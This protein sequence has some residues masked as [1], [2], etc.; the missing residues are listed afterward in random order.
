MKWLPLV[1]AE[2]AAGAILAPGLKVRF[3][4]GVNMPSYITFRISGVYLFG[5]R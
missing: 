2:V 4:G 1:K 5:A 3:S